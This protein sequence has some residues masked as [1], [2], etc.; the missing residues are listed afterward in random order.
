MSKMIGTMIKIWKVERKLNRIQQDN[1]LKQGQQVADL[2]RDL[3][4]VLPDRTAQKELFYRINGIHTWIQ[5]KT[6]LVACF[7]AA[8]AAIFACICTVVALITVFSN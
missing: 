8:V 3:K 1:F 7:W 4:L 6:M 5:T 2:Q